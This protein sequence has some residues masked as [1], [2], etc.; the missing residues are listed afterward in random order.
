MK[1]PKSTRVAGVTVKIVERDLSDA[2][3]FGYW[4]HDKKT[5]YI[6]QNLSPKLARQTLCHEMI[7][8]ALD[9]SGIS[10]A[11]GFPDEPVVRAVETLFL[12]AWERMKK[13]L[14]KTNTDSLC[15]QSPSSP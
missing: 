12:P 14:A 11:K 5:I 10:F 6:G 4:N 9:L 13:R 8:A 1:L 15:Q 7:H 3:C 2:E